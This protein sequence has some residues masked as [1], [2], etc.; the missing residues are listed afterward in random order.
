[1]TRIYIKHGLKIIPIGKSKKQLKPQEEVFVKEE[2]I[3]Y[4]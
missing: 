3:E 1:M 2:D 4:E